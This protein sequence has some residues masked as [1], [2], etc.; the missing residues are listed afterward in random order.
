MIKSV[1]VVNPAGDSLVLEL[2]KPE[3]V[4]IAISS[5]DGIGPPEGVINI[6]D[7]SSTDGGRFSS[8]RAEK[9]N[10]TMKLLFLDSYGI[11]E[12]R[13]LS[14]KF[15]PVKGKIE[16]Y[17]E[18]SARTLKTEGFV[19][20]NEVP[21]FS[22]EEGCNVSIICP[23]PYFYSFD[24]QENLYTV[25]DNLF[26][27]PYSNESLTE[28]LTNF[29]NLSQINAKDIVYEGDASTGVTI[30]INA[31]GDVGD[32]QIRN[33]T[34][35]EAMKISSENLRKV[36]GTALTSGDQLIIST[37]KGNKYVTLVRDS[38]NYNVINAVD[39]ESDWIQVYQGENTFVIDG[40]E[41]AR[42][43]ISNRIVY[44]GV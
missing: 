28:K 37:T 10:I 27:F 17:F 7:Y 35:G 1:T 11:E 16:L 4:G 2:R 12:A 9:R 36:A 15:F 44:E 24:T 22:K 39:K 31:T 23:D 18:T 3:K 40:G 42:I 6:A 25:V 43:T 14:Y 8:S 21:I 26:E 33:A 38:T 30:H 20:R 29:A 34:A 32:I 41:N 13:H 19:E 5:I